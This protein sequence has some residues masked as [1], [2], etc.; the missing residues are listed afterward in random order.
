M[1]PQYPLFDSL[2]TTVV[3]LFC[4]FSF[5]GLIA[6]VSWIVILFHNGERA[7]P[8]IYAI[9]WT[10]IARS[11]IMLVVNL[12]HFIDGRY[13][14]EHIGC[15]IQGGLLQVLAALG[16]VSFLSLIL[17]PL[18]IIILKRDR[19]SHRE[20][21]IMVGINGVLITIMSSLILLTPSAYVLNPARVSAT[22]CYEC[23]TSIISMVAAGLNIA[24]IFSVPIIM[25]CVFWYSQY[26]ISHERHLNGKF[27]L[28]IIKLQCALIRRGMLMVTAHMF[29]FYP[30]LLETILR[31]YH[32]NWG[33]LS[34]VSEILV[35]MGFS[36]NPC[37]M[38]YLD[39]HFSRIFKRKSRHP[40]D[41]IAKTLAVTN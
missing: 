8:F 7:D 28:T 3:I 1:F 29:V 16:V 24:V 5:I 13:S 32:V 37:V 30:Y 2:Q 41:T 14:T 6:N 22:I 18:M 12:I 4:I 23:N 38:F 17:D 20:K 36:I 35:V 11:V 21:L 33:Y 40:V 15:Q 10:D 39:G 31:I 27:P 26:S 19:I 25:V 34:F 9:A